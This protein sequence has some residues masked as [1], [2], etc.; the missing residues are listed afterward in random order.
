[1]NRTV[2]SDW[3]GEMPILDEAKGMD[4]K[5]LL[6][7]GMENRRHRGDVQRPCQAIVQA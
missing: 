2:R 7:M 1:M 5:L 3:Q 4:N 6:D